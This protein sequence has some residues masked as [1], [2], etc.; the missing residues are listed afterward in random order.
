MNHCGQQRFVII[1]KRRLHFYTPFHCGYATVYH[2][3][4]SFKNHC[5]CTPSEYRKM[6]QTQII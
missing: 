6:T 3:C 2:F 5:N 1:Q 4:R